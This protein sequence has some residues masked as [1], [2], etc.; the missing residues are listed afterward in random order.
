MAEAGHEAGGAGEPK[1]RR[2]RSP[3]SAL[4][5]DSGRFVREF[6][7][8]ESKVDQQELQKINVPQVP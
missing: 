5:D 1:S 3:F 8:F 7:F 2:P 4:V 6:V